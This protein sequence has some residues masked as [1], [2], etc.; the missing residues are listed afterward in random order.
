MFVMYL[1][2]VGQRKAYVSFWTKST[3][4]SLHLTILLVFYAIWIV[5]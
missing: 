2:F 3:D 4:I 1:Y 5:T